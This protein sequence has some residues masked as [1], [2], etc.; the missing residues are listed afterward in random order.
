MNARGRPGST[1][2]GMRPI[3]RLLAAVAVALLLGGCA[4]EQ[5]DRPAV[6]DS[7]DSVQAS[8]D[9]LRNATISEN[10]LSQVRTDLEELRHALVQLVDDARAQ[11]ATE[12]DTIEKAAADLR[13]AVTAA[14]ADPGPMTLSAVGDAAAWLRETVHRLGT[15][16]AD[17][18]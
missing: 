15:A 14:R 9:D 16:M 8:A 1:L 18:C 4:E 17:T 6:C 10:G 3:S 5:Q 13:T 7:Y 12:V 11:Y 2:A